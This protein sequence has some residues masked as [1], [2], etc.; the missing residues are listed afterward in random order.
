MN[1]PTRPLSFKL[2]IGFLTLFASFSALADL[3]DMSRIFRQTPSLNNFEVCY[4]GGCAEVK[5]V[6]LTSEEWQKVAAIFS[7][8]DNSAVSAEQERKQI[9]TGIALLETIVGAKIGTSN[10]LAGTFFEGHL[11]GQQDCNDEA[12]NTTTYM[13]LM[14]QNGLVRQHEIE[15]TRTRNFFFT[16][17]P[18]STAVIR[19]SKTSERF[20]VDSWFYDNGEPP[21]IVPFKQWK[22]GYRP[23][24]SPVD[25]RKAAQVNSSAN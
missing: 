22:S 12:I 5:P 10:D 8:L 23:A 6:A 7:H 9:A 15:D 1:Y 2:L 24:D 21:V 18:H 19:E 20:A 14:R 3:S 4:A 17:W 16:G 25:N 11:S 13:R